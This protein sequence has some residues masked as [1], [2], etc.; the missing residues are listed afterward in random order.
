MVDI[1]VPQTESATDIW[2]F[3]CRRCAE[4]CLL[5]SLLDSTRGS[6]V[7]LYRCAGCGEIVWDEGADAI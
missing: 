6:T 1:N 5:Y 7:R 2:P 3:H 4:H